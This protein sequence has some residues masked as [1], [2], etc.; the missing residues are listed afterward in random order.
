MIF[1]NKNS[2][3]FEMDYNN[4][5]MGNIE[6]IVII[7]ISAIILVALGYVFYRRRIIVLLLIS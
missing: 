7:F 6:K 5:V 1:K 3:N 4:Y 2:E